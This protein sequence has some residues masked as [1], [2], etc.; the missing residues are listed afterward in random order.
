MFVM[1]HSG[2]RS[3]GKTICDEF[4]KRALAQNLAWHAQ[5]PHREL[6]YLPVGTNDFVGYW[7]AMEFALRFAEVN[8]SRM[9]DVT[10]RA[11]GGTRGR[12][13][14]RLVDVH[15][16]Y[17]A[18]ENYL[19]ERHRSP[20]GRRARSGGRSVLIPGSMGTASY[21]ARVSAMP[22][23]SRRASTAPAGP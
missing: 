6:A 21:V 16:N 5:L 14:R 17:A 7:S 1:L 9:L 8:R 19:A 15:H 4:H 2:S 13:V 10:E 12:A 11:F 3:L 18:W 23:R 20:Q 22:S